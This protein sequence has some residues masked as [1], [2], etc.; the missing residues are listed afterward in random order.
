[1][2]RTVLRGCHLC[3]AGCGLRIEVEDD[4]IVSVRP[5]D[6]DPLSQGYVCPKG[7]AI[8]EVHDDPDRLRR[9]VRR[10]PDGEFRE[11]SWD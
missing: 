6:D 9:P 7:M 1:M 2:T 5:D 11:I 4:R 3:E 8:A 10:G